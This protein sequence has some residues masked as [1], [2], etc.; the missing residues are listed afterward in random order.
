M[1]RSNRSGLSSE[2]R[3]F[4]QIPRLRD[5]TVRTDGLDGLERPEHPARWTAI[6]AKRGRVCCSAAPLRSRDHLSVV[7]RTFSSGLCWLS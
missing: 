7:R 3:L 2:G 1:C 4:E 5:R 6:P